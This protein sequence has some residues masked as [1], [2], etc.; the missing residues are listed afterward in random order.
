MK[1]VKKIITTVLLVLSLAIGPVSVPLLNYATVEAATVNINNTKLSVYV[2]NTY[3][4]KLSG[5]TTKVKWASSNTKIA[6]VTSAGKVKGVKKDIFYISIK[7]DT[8]HIDYLKRMARHNFLYLIFR[9]SKICSWLN[10]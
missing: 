3:T 2:V 9:C 7:L 5:T 8:G 1:R 6:T 4:L 10:I